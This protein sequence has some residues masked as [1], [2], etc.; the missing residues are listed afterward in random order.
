MRV[1]EEAITRYKDEKDSAHLVLESW[2]EFIEHQRKKGQT[3]Q[4]RNPMARCSNTLKSDSPTRVLR[5]LCGSGA[6]QLAEYEFDEFKKIEIANTQEAALKI[7][8]AHEE[9]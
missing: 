1:A 2:S 6:L 7:V 4:P 8:Q 9:V 5:Q 3:A